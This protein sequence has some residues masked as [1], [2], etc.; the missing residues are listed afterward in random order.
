MNVVSIVL[1]GWVSSLVGGIVGLGGGF[2]LIPILTLL[3]GWDD[4]DA[5]FISITSIFVLALLKNHK[6]RA[7]IKTHRQLLISLA[8]FSILGSWLFTLVLNVTP[9][10]YLARGF[11]ILMISVGLF[12]L[13]DKNPEALV[14]AQKDPI[15]KMRFAIFFS[16]ALSGLFGVGGGIINVPILHKIKRFDMK[17]AASLSFFFIF[18]SSLSAIITQLQVRRAAI[19][20]IPISHLVAIISGT[21]IGFWTNRFVPLGNHGIKRLFAILVIFVGLSKLLGSL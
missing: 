9:S 13:V 11:A 17:T 8:L 19:D 20:Q 12:F 15:W 14:D 10:L 2:I 3:L 6:N 16:G 4:K 7:L 5:I 21:L 18:I 1:A